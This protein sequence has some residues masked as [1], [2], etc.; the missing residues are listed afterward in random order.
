MPSV[1]TKVSAV[2]ALADALPN[3]DPSKHPRDREGRFLEVGDPVSIYTATGAGFEKT[4]V[5]KVKGGHF[6]TSTGRM[7]IA[8]ETPEGETKWYRPKQ[9]ETMEVK[10]AL[11]PQGPIPEVGGKEDF[12]WVNDAGDPISID[13]V[14]AL[15]KNPE[16]V[17]DAPD[18]MLEDDEPP[19]A[20]GFPDEDELEFPAALTDEEYFGEP[21]DTG[22]LPGEFPEPEPGTKV[23]AAPSG[24]KAYVAPDGTVTAYDSDGGQFNLPVTGDQLEAGYGS[25]VLETEVPPEPEDFGSLFPDPQ[26][27]ALV[28]EHPQGAKIYVNTDGSMEAYGA[29]GKKKNTSATPE[30]LAAGHGQWKL[31]DQSAELQESYS[32]ILAQVGF[33]P[34]PDAFAATPEPAAPGPVA[35]PAAAPA[36]PPIKLPAGKTPA[37]MLGM[38]ETSIDNKYNAGTL[39]PGESSLAKDYLAAALGNPDPVAAHKDLAK[40]M[41]LAKLGGK[42][43]ARYKQLLDMHLGVATPTPTP[44]P[45]PA[46]S[47]LTPSVPGGPLPPVAGMTKPPGAKV[48]SYT[49]GKAVLQ[50]PVALQPWQHHVDVYGGVNQSAAKKA[51]IQHELAQRTL[52][53]ITDAQIEGM[54]TPGFHEPQRTIALRQELANL[55]PGATS[56]TS[57]LKRDSNGGWTVVGKSTLKTPPGFDG[58]YQRELNAEN[59]RLSLREIVVADLVQQWAATSNDTN[60]RSLAI[61]HAVAAEFKLTDFQPWANEPASTQEY[62]AK[63]EALL[64]AFVRAMYD[65]TQEDLKK[66]GVTH[67]ALKRGMHISK[68]GNV[69]ETVRMKLR[70]ASS[71]TSDTSIANRFGK[72]H[73]TAYVPIERI[74]G[75]AHNGF[76]CLHEIEWVT[77]GG[78]DEYTISK[79]PI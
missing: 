25:W 39:S 26:P 18:L 70:P 9:L 58:S 65:F 22:E 64:R 55:P 69:G 59:L 33:P 8:V 56:G 67:I 13:E 54:P 16:A 42:Q 53:T 63:N 3:W 52:M 29:N 62:Y 57:I 60:P 66:R 2:G 23:Y 72:T 45:K 50:E 77:L 1:K 30:K 37:D 19:G 11:T 46:A 20:G 27:G 32:D 5:G 48:L 7:F 49:A 75:S 21:L 47:A 38:I 35:A 36:A 73:I 44:T 15:S 41:T 43:R 40:A 76:G 17:L 68:P 61:Q 4:G 28:Y 6:E 34:D 31:T 71:F 79:L 78:E 12:D 51:R 24:N 14:V 74:L 10:A